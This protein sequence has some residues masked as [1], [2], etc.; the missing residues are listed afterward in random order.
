MKRIIQS[1]KKRDAVCRQTSGWSGNPQET[2]HQRKSSE[3]E[4]L[5]G[6]STSEKVER[7]GDQTLLLTGV[8]GEFADSQ[9]GVCECKSVNIYKGE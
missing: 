1:G 3:R 6:E 2:P 5:E 8:S 4:K 9:F 7:K